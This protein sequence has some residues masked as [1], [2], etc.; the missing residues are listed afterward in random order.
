MADKAEPTESE[1]S[2]SDPLSGLQRFAAAVVGT[3]A[4]GAGGASVF[5]TSNQAGSVALLALGA[6]FL[7]MSVNGMPILGAKLK[8]YELTMAPRR[9]RVLDQA[10]LEP[11]EEAKLALDV[12]QQIDPG[13]SSDPAFAQVRGRLYHQEVATAL[14]RVSITEFPESTIAR[15]DYDDGAVVL[16]I[17]PWFI[18]VD[19]RYFSRPEQMGSGFSRIVLSLFARAQN[20]I[21]GQML[22]TN[23]SLS[24]RRIREADQAYPGAAERVQIIRW[25]DAQDD[26]ALK[27]AVA[28]LMSSYPGRD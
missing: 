9:R 13:A 18:D 8:D 11:P 19:V 16:R 20:S 28:Q 6:G 25:V 22:V 2:T 17:G 3:A 12:L 23:A 21:A 15:S 26:P 24:D 4:S 7:I 5:L 14:L 10:R 27:R 1:P